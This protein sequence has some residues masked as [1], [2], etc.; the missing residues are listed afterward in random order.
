MSIMSKEVQN[1]LSM[2]QSAFSFDPG[3]KVAIAHQ[4]DPEREALAPQFNV[5]CRTEKLMDEVVSLCSSN[6]WSVHRLGP[7]DV[8]LDPTPNYI[9]HGD[10]NYS[11]VWDD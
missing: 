2:V 4:S 7:Q 11:S 6:G 3:V 5:F 9:S 1:S 10:E 8:H